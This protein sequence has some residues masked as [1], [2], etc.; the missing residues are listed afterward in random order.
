LPSLPVRAFEIWNEPDGG[1]FWVPRPDAAR[2]AQL[3]SDA[4][5]AIH[6]GDPGARVVI[7]GLE[8]AP[9]FM[10]K[11][12]AADPQLRDGIDGVAIHPYAPS[13]AAVLTTVAAARRT[14]D[15]LGLGAVPLYVTEFGWT[16]S[17][18]GALDYLPAALRPGYIGFTLVGLGRSGCGI[19]AAT[20]YT[21]F[22]LERN[23]ADGQQWFGI[24]P[25]GGRGSSDVTAFA[26]GVMAAEQSRAGSRGCG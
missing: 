18:P 20:L 10:P 17:P 21:W 3:Y 19:A 7:G 5:R 15:Q 12:L 14:L 24:S 22:S 8:S 1:A 9:G 2:Y 11:L 26:K 23:P 16:T 6:A 25:P 4:R 13:P